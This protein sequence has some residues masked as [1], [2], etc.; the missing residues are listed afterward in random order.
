[1]ALELQ[2]LRHHELLMLSATFV[3]V[4]L[5]NEQVL[6]A[7]RILR[8][9]LLR[10]DKLRQ[11]RQHLLPH[12]RWGLRVLLWNLHVVMLSTLLQLGSLEPAVQY[13]VL[14]L[15]EF[16]VEHLEL[17]GSGMHGMQRLLGCIESMHEDELHELHELDSWRKH[18]SL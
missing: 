6:E 2:H 10:Y 5:H 18:L 9:K 8:G 16:S 14:Q 15:D 11:L 4:L 1:M 7:G 13:A 17:Y 12:K 3:S